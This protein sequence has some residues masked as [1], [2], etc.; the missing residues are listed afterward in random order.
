VVYGNQGDLKEFF[1]D[2]LSLDTMLGY[3]AGRTFFHIF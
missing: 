2:A 3:F 1:F